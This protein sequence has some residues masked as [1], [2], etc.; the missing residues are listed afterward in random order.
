M[1]IDD[2]LRGS[3]RERPGVALLIVSIVWLLGAMVTAGLFALLMEIDSTIDL[4]RWLLPWAL[5]VY[6]YVCWRCWQWAVHG[7]HLPHWLR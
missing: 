6:T 1:K 5:V 3:M 2:E 4:I 7:R